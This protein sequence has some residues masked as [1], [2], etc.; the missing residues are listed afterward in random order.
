MP[1]EEQKDKDIVTFDNV[2]KTKDAAG[3]EVVPHQS[4][5]TAGEEVEAAEEAMEE[6]PHC[7]GDHTLAECP[8][9]TLEQLEEIYA[10]LGVE[11]EIGKGY[12]QLC[13]E[14][15]FSMPD[16]QSKKLEFK[17]SLSVMS[18]HFPAALQQFPMM[19]IWV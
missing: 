5:A 3:N 7:N 19:E 18:F 17:A 4:H 8:D 9:L 14:D 1:K 6:C 11:E 13:E 2:D 16:F 10:Q 12:L 15:N